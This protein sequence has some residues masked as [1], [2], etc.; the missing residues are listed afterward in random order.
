MLPGFPGLPDRE[1]ACWGS[2]PVAR[3]GSRH[4]AV[5][6]ETAVRLRTDS[7]GNSGG[8]PCWRLR[9]AWP[10]SPS[11]LCSHDRRPGAH[12]VQMAGGGRGGLAP[13]T[14][15]TAGGGVPGTQG[16]RGSASSPDPSTRD[17]G[18]DHVPGAAPAA[19][20]AS[21]TP[22]SGSSVQGGKGREPTSARGGHRVAEQQGLGGGKPQ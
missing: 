5:P 16:Q 6:M 8:R 18:T 1:Q 15:P 4:L 19:G 12:S 7:H 9:Q 11:S 21:Q 17:S 20:E 13:P 22:F 3:P 14:R 2:E 10:L